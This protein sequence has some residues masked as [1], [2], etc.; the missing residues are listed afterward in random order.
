MHADFEGCVSLHGLI[1]AD[2][3][4]SRLEKQIADKQK[5]L[6]ATLAKL[7]NESFV[8]SAAGGGATACAS[9]RMN[10]NSRSR[11]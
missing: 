8:S 10:W 11:Y 3:E 7:Q 2:V 9:W 4:A 5:H 1:D 6:Q